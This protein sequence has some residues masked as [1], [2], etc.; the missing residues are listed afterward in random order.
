MLHPLTLFP[1]L[2]SYPFLAYLILRLVVTYG[3]GRIALMRWKKS[4]KYV[5]LVEA[6]ATILVLVGLY[7]Q[8][9]LIAVII[10]I[11]VDWILDAKTM[12][13][14]PVEKIVSTIICVVAMALLFLGPGA[15][16]LDYPL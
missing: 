4:C 14:I 5:A 7:T 11:I 16:A 2:L 15:F 1:S 12:T 8:A 9:A 13:Q 10:L 3:I 6:V